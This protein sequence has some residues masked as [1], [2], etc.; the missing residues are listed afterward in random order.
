MEATIS[1]SFLTI[2]ASS[3]RNLSSVFPQSQSHFFHNVRL[4]FSD[5][6]FFHVQHILF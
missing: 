5:V 4:N 1:A 2:V 3:A 6:P